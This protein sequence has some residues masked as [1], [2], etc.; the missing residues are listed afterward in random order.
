MGKKLFVLFLSLI[1]VPLSA[2]S[3]LAKDEG[4]IKIGILCRSERGLG[5]MGKRCGKGV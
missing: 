4:P 5:A 1:L 2:G 3:L